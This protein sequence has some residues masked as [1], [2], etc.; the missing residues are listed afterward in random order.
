MLIA[1]INQ[2]TK[3]SNAD[4]SIMAKAV[5][6]QMTL[7]VSPAWNQRTPTIKFY[8]DHT[9]V[10]GYA[11]TV[12]VLDDSTQAGALGYHSVDDNKV[13]AFIFAGPVLDNGGVTLYDTHNP[14]NV[15]V[16][17]VL[18]HEVCEMFID[19]FANEWADGPSITKGSQYAKELCDPVE[20]DSYAIP[21]TVGAN[22]IEVSV[23]NFIFPSWFN[24]QAD[25]SNFPF[26]YMKKL[27]A[28]FTMSP[29]GYMIIQ[30]TFNIQELFG[31]HDQ[32]I[33]KS[34]IGLDLHL[35][36]SRDMP[37]WRKDQVK[38]EWYRR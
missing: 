18:S 2:S 16:S 31:H 22:T 29:G 13:D 36:M 9:K 19:R 37:M 14:Q 20:A 26:D 23:S 21:V 4:V 8:A 5:Q 24:A 1:I 33:Y 30:S 7:H 12:N 25:A 10:P 11:W 15:S 3:V 28:P 27:K 6:K 34:Q 32:Y 35:I 38:A 17:S